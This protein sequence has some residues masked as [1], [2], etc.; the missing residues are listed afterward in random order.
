MHDHSSHGDIMMVGSGMDGSHSAHN[1]GETLHTMMT[2]DKDATV[3]GLSESRKTGGLSLK[4]V[5]DEEDKLYIEVSCGDQ[6]GRLYLEKFGRDSKQMSKA[7]CICYKGKFIS[8]QE[9]ETVGGKKPAKAWR[10]SIKH[11]EK[12]LVKFMVDEVLSEPLLPATFSTTQIEETPNTTSQSATA[13]LRCFASMLSSI[14]SN[15]KKSS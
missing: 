7:Q 6:E 10:K 12:P 2:Q 4:T 1:V 13:S 3:F 9:F 11:D 5:M 15:L 14:E 8:P